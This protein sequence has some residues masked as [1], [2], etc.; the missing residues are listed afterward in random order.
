MLLLIDIGNTHTHVGR[1]KRSGQGKIQGQMR[2]PTEWWA[3]G[4]AQ[5]RLRKMLGGAEPHAVALCSVVPKAS[6]AA[7]QLC[8]ELRVPHFELSAR[9]VRGLGIRYPRPQT[10]GAD[11]IANALA[12]VHHFGSPS[13]AVDFGT[14]VTFDVVDGAGNYVGGIIGPGMAILSEY[15]HEKTAL[16]PRIRLRAVDR[17]IGRS[18]EEAM[19]IGAVRGYRGLVRQ[20]VAELKTALR[21]PRLPVIATGGD[22]RLLTRGMRE[23]TAV[24]PDLTLEGIRLAWVNAQEPKLDI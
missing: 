11:R 12:C 18:T 5:G 15:L 20:L 7:R 2:L 23:I 16:L 3:S 22:A 10:I 17:I 14:A 9:T 13:I 6:R 21:A 19:L 8:R 1:V 4:R 24:R